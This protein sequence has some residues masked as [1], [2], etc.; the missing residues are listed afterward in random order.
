MNMV[1]W[2]ADEEQDSALALSCRRA[3]PQIVL[4]SQDSTFFFHN[5]SIRGSGSHN[6]MFLDIDLE[7]P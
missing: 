4:A 1:I 7:E 3:Q 2:V 5:C 6:L